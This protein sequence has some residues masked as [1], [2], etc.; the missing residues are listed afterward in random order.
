MAGVDLA[1]PLKPS[2][3]HHVPP[4]PGSELQELRFSL[5]DVDLA[6]VWPF[7]AVP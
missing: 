2:L 7:F 3:V 5:L 6:L 4:R 1:K